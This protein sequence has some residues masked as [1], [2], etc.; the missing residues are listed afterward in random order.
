MLSFLMSSL[1]FLLA[2]A[3]LI[4][5]AMAVAMYVFQRT[6]MYPAPETKRIAPAAAGF[7]QAQEHVLDTA[8]GEKIIVWHVPPQAGKPVVMF[9]HGNGEVIAWR[10]PRFHDL[11]AEGVGTIAVSYRGYGGSTGS[12]S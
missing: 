2:A 11:A 12:P 6:V 8:D 7:P 10:V 1:K 4:Y 9:F 3:V 5:A